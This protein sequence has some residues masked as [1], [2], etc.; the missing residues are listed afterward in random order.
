MSQQNRCARS[1]ASARPSEEEE[2]D[3]VAL[4]DA[5][6]ALDQTAFNRLYERYF[7]RIYN[8]VYARIR[9]HADTEEIVQETFAA[10]FRSIDAFRGQSSLVSWIYGI[11]KN[12]VNNH[13]RRAKLRDF[14][15]ELAEP[16]AL[17]PLASMGDTPED[18]L[19]LRRYT[20]A[21][22][23]RLGSV[24]SWQAEVFVLR[25]VENLPIQEIARRTSRSS[26]AVRSSLYRVKRLLVAA[27]G[28][29]LV[30][31]AS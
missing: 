27:G 7:Q 31:T 2:G 14:W 10:V 29:E 16:D 22:R 6:R 24:A 5:V 23:E 8:F 4:V 17:L 12:T 30:T 15:V 1:T 20:D 18:A 21:I 13:L 19:S 28:A 25:H 9:H 26:D 3:E 11:A